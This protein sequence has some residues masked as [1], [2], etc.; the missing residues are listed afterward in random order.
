MRFLLDQ[1]AD[2]RL[3]PYLSSLGHD[4]TRV[5][6]DYPGGIPDTEVLR[7][8]VDEQRIL[9]TDDRDF[10]E[11]VVDRHLPHRGVIFFRLGDYA[12]LATKIER[13]DHVLSHFS[14]R[15]DQFLTVTRQRVRVRTS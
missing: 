8:A 5:G 10:G 15:L 6:H 7:L 2:A 4:V 9:I 1:S 14:D 3:V 13:L 12:P 11:L